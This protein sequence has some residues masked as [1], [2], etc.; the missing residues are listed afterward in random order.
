VE[1][2]DR[3]AARLALFGEMHADAGRESNVAEAGRVGR[4]DG[5]GRDERGAEY[6]RHERNPHEMGER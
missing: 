4:C 6:G 3:L 1:Q 5:D 2:D